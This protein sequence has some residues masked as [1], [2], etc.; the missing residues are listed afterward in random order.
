MDPLFTNKHINSNILR[1]QKHLTNDT[2]NS[3]IIASILHFIIVLVIVYY[4]LYSYN[5]NK[6]IF[7]SYQLSSPKVVQLFNFS[8][9]FFKTYFPIFQVSQA[10]FCPESCTRSQIYAGSIPGWNNIFLQG[11]YRVWFGKKTKFF[12]F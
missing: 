12:C 11:K 9:Q 2:G 7:S 3:F 8:P 4:L 10:D 5:Y 1:C 6:Q